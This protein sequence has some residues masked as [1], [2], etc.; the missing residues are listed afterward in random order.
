[1]KFGL[2]LCQVHGRKCKLHIDETG[3]ASDGNNSMMPWQGER[4]NMIDR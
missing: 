4:T 2:Y 3:T 1:M